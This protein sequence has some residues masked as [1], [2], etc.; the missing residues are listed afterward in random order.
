MRKLSDHDAMTEARRFKTLTLSR[1]VGG[2]A[3]GVAMP[4]PTAQNQM[5]I[6]NA[7]LAWSLLAAPTAEFQVPI[8][9]ADPYTPVWAA[10]TIGAISDLAYAVPALTLSTANAEGAADTVIRSDATILV[11]DATVPDV[12]QPDDAAAAGSAVVAARRDHTHGIV[13]AAPASP[14]VNL[15]ASAEG[16]GTSFARDDHTHQL[17][18]GIA[19]TWTALHTFAAHIALSAATSHI[20]MDTADGTD[21]KRIALCGGGGF[22]DTRGGLIWLAGNEYTGSEG[23]ISIVAGNVANG[24]IELW[25]GAARRMMITNAGIVTITA[26]DNVASAMAI[27]DVGGTEY[28]RIV[29]T[30]A[31]P[32]VVFNEGGADVDHRWEASGEANALF[33]RG[34]DG[35]KSMGTD[36]PESE[37]HIVATAVTNVHRSTGYGTPTLILDDGSSYAVTLQL[38]AYDT[39]VGM[40]HI[41]MTGAPA[42]G[43]NKHWIISHLGSEANNRFTI[44]YVT[45]AATGF[46]PYS[47][48]TEYVTI[49][50]AGV[51]NVDAGGRLRVRNGAGGYIELGPGDATHLGYIQWFKADDTRLGYMGHYNDTDIILHLENSADLAVLGGNVSMG[52]ASPATSAKL[53]LSST[54]GALLL[55]RMT[56]AQRDALTAVNGMVIYN[57]TT[58]AFNFYENG[59]WV[60]K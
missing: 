5:I 38:A 42:S 16:T 4:Q 41:I 2:G 6:A 17:D 40:C 19:P 59:A 32:V 23:E 28:M 8:A 57:S 13:C 14:S 26:A 18:Q 25:T 1:A 31:Q 39:S 11:F 55:T 20:R 47:G 37:L 7:T 35:R 44:G 22:A 27:G 24:A 49:S 60:T 53:E 12:I 30:D 3:G 36:S 56:T 15:A 21:N 46:S 54:T 33:V 52:T 34:S 10:L 45:S 58:T 43:D 50:T 48:V 29:S 51:V 9:G